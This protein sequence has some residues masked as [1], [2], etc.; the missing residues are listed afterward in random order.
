LR[1][2]G[3][4]VHKINFNGG[5]LLFYPTGSIW[6]RGGAQ[7]WP[8]FVEET[9]KRLSIDAILLFGDCRP[10]HKAARLVA[11]RLGVQVGAFEEGYIRP[12]YITF[13][14]FGVNGHSL[15]SRSPE[16]FADL[17]AQPALPE[18]QL[19]RTFWYAALWAALYYI[20]ADALRTLF[21]R[22][23]HHRP[24]TILEGIWWVRGTWRK[25]FYLRRERGLLARLTTELSGRFFLVPLQISTDAQIV[26][27]SLYDSV[28]QFIRAT[29]ASFARHA[30]ADTVLAVKHHPLDRGYHDYRALLE[31]LEE[32]HGLTGR[33]Y[34]LHDQHL[35]T[36]FDHMRGAV[37]INSTVGF[38]ALSHN[39]PVKVCGRAI[40]SLPGMTYQ[41]SL[42]SFWRQAPHHKPDR[43]LVERFRSYVIDETQINGSFYKA[44]DQ[45]GLCRSVNSQYAA[46]PPALTATPGLAQLG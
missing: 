21:H 28:V 30:P 24:L 17:P 15:M 2:A 46:T 12:N 38:S 42:E 36:L 31:A 18:K 43:L 25:F 6:Y 44:T 27:H 20:A 3:A 41:D 1:E 16:F 39:A 8:A 9:I 33:L 34:Y 13:E 45:S 11:D 37:V 32:E 35:P 22:Y 14:N 26:E 29:V 7:E 5:D 10:L 4:E 40:Y 19:G 23:R